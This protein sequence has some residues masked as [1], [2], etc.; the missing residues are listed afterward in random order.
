MTA[1][2]ILFIGMDVHKESIVVSLVDDDRGNVRRYGAI[3]GALPDFKKLLRKL[4]TT[5]KDLFFCYEA[6]PCGNVSG[7]TCRKKSIPALYQR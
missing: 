2:N 6:G 7:Q 5:G 3:G 4:S 1:S